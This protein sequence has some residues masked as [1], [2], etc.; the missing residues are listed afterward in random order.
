MYYNFHLLITQRHCYVWPK[1]PSNA[2]LRAGT[3][4]TL[5]QAPDTVQSLIFINFI[6]PTG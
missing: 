1:K 3:Y 6:N 2:D 5:A 4:A